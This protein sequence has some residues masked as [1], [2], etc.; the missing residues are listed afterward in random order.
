MIQANELRIG[1]L[2]NITNH[3]GGVK[4]VIGISYD[5]MNMIGKKDKPT[6]TVY[7]SQESTFASFGINLVEPIPLTEEWLLRFGFKK[8]GKYF[9]IEEND[10]LVEQGVDKFFFGWE[11]NWAATN[12]V[13]LIHVHQLQ[14]LYFA[15]TANE[16]TLN[17]RS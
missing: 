8:K 4:S 16:L 6:I 12:D 11:N 7:Y 14:N 13:E 17:A 9:E 10:F 1:N 15:L 3:D 5:F 2:V